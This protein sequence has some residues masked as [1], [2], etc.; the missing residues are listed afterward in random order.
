[1]L[2][3]GTPLTTSAHHMQQNSA[4]KSL[5]TMQAGLDIINNL[6]AFQLIVLARY[7]LG[8]PKP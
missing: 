2:H 7:L 6:Q 8:V 4:A 3:S 5:L 1:M